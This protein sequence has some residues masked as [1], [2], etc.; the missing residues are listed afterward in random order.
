MHTYV[1]FGQV[2]RHSLWVNY[3]IARV[4]DANPSPYTQFVDTYILHRYT[5]IGDVLPPNR[6]VHRP[7]EPPARHA[8]V[9]KVRV[10]THRRPIDQ[11]VS[12]G[13]DFAFSG[14]ANGGARHVCMHAC[15]Q[16]GRRRGRSSKLVW[17]GWFGGTARQEV[18]VA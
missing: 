16:A 14:P 13:A 6:Q 2:R 15:R 9:V 4:F 11:L 8:P 5:P 18:G 12:I 7:P 10:V 17:V 1:Q 3:I